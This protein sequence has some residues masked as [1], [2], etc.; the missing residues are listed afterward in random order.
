MYSTYI[1]IKI[2]SIN[3]TYKIVKIPIDSDYKY[4]NGLYFHNYNHS[5]TSLPQFFNN[6]IEV[7]CDEKEIKLRYLNDNKFF[8]TVPLSYLEEIEKNGFKSFSNELK[9]EKNSFILEK[10][11]ENINIT[12]GKGSVFF[13]N[14]ES[15]ITFSVVDNATEYK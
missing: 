14:N 1:E 13:E 9:S 15:K 4:I 7:T 3:S 2:K 6:N 5:F 8:I 12:L 11:G 10:N